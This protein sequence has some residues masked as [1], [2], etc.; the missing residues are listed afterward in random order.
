M[1]QARSKTFHLERGEAGARDVTI[2]F[3]VEPTTVGEEAPARPQAALQPPLPGSGRGGDVLHEVEPSFGS[4]D[5][6]DLGQSR[7]EIGHRAQNERGQHRIEGCVIG[8]ET[9]SIQGAKAR[10]EASL[11]RPADK[12]LAH[13]RIGLDPVPL[14]P[15]GEVE[16][17]H[18]R[19]GTEFQNTTSYGAEQ[20][21]P[22][23]TQLALVAGLRT[24]IEAGEESLTEGHDHESTIPWRRE[25]PRA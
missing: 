6:P 21:G 20:C 25:R 18:T 14:D 8:R 24:V 13:V 19:P 17:V 4:K 11:P 7:L 15:V 22:S 16:E 23:I 3:P 5:A 1:W 2:R 12:P 10:F 9:R